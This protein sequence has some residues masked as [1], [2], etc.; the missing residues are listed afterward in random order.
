MSITNILTQLKQMTEISSLVFKD[1]TPIV[2]VKDQFS[3][4]VYLNICINVTGSTKMG[5]KGQYK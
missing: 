5:I 4:L 3:H 2:I 1:T